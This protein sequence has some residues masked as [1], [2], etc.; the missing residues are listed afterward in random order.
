MQ[1][2]NSMTSFEHAAKKRQAW[3]REFSSTISLRGRSPSDGKGQRK[4]TPS[5]PRL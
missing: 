3:F 4:P 1:R 2:G 5:G